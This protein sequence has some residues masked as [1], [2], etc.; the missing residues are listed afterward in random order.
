MVSGHICQEI[1][2]WLVTKIG[3]ILKMLYIYI[4]SFLGKNWRLA[5]RPQKSGFKAQFMLRSLNQ[6]VMF[7][8]HSIQILP[9]ISLIV[10]LLQPIALNPYRLETFIAD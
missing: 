4:S 3:K 5:S 8:T 10:L 9:P 6:I 7:R 1:T 2:S